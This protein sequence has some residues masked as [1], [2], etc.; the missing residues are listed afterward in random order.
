MK[1]ALLCASL[2]LALISTACN[3][4]STKNY[5]GVGGTVGT[6]GASIEAKYKATDALVLRGNINHLPVSGDES[7]DGVDY[8][9]DIDMTTAG[10]F[11]DMHPFRNGFH[12]S[13]GVYVGEKS[14]SLL[15]MP[16][17]ATVVEIGDQ[18]YTGAE[19][20]TLRGR[21]EYSDISPFLGV[22]MDGFIDKSR[23][24]SMSLRGGIM[25]IG[26]PD[27]D[28][29]AEGG[30]SSDLPAVQDD[31]VRE[32]DNLENE[33]DDYQ[34]YPVLTVGVTRHF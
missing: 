2:G 34:L 28:L 18:S 24:W 16:S 1:T 23:D 20:G 31:L 9:A 25:F 12:I 33:L 32:A 22:G 15:G 3:S 27:V 11:A 6:T 26:E 7:Y 4:Y 29:V 19:I 10:L 5:W 30:L 17:A 8:E 21:A 13:T 14:A